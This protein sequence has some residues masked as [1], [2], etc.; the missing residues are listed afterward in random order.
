MLISL[1]GYSATKST[2]DTIRFYFDIDVHSV[3]DLHQK[4]IDSLIPSIT[5]QN[6]KIELL[7]YADY[8]GNTIYNQNLSTHRV[9]N[10][11]KQLL[12]KGILNEQIVLVKGNGAIDP[13]NNVRTAAGI[14]SHRKVEMLIRKP[15]PTETFNKPTES[16]KEDKRIKVEELN[17]GDKFVWEN[18]NFYGGRHVLLPQSVP[19]LEKLLSLLR[20]Y[21]NL[22]IEIQGHICCERNLE[23]GY[24]IDTQTYNLSLNRAKTVYNFLIQNGINANRLSYVGF[25]RKYPII[26]NEFTAEDYTTNRRVEIKIIEK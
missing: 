14:P 17:A 2:S 8:L 4:V 13:G 25:G 10:V 15:L 18:L 20:D 11:K 12:T 16:P 23:D 1:S 6:L 3:S 21:P 19:S 5:S 24:D 22:K 26:E 7:G 9:E